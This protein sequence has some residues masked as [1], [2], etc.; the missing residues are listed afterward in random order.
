MSIH[1]KTGEP[2]VPASGE[3]V[4]A[5]LRFHI[6]IETTPMPVIYHW[7]LAL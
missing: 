7:R 2:Y 3:Y 6:R 1:A 4:R 5:G